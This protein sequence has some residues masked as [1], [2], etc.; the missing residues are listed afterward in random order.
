MGSCRAIPVLVLATVL[1][2]VVAA[3]GEPITL[4]VCA[5][6][7]PS[8]TEE[9][10]P[11]MDSFAAG[12]E[13]AAGWNAGRLNAVY[14]PTVDGSLESLAG[15]RAA[16][17]VVPLHFYLKFGE[18]FDLQ[19]MLRVVQAAGEE[20]IWSLVAHRGSLRGAGSLAGW[21]ILG[22][23]GYAPEFVRQIALVDWGT[24]PAEVEIDFTSRVLSVLRKAAA[25]EDVA[26]LL[27]TAQTDAL[28]SLPFAGD[29]EVVARSQP[30]VGMLLCRVGGRI[31]DEDSRELA[32]AFVELDDSAEGKSLLETI[33]IQRFDELAPGTLGPV[34]KAYRGEGEMGR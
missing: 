29:L 4:V 30:L 5:P 31:D 28:E 25:G 9:A 24:L 22:M 17:A 26:A 7:Y 20:E 32:A 3:A 13:A 23:P 11:T 8:N 14:H 16:L 12:V 27:D 10:Q 18:R 19:P 2:A 33:R 34:E 21:K 1:L 15:E 6:G